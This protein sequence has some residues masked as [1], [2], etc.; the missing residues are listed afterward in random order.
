[1]LLL[2]LAFITLTG[3]YLAYLYGRKTKKFK[4]SEYT[5][6][7]VFPLIFILYMSYHQ[8]II[9]LFFVISAVSGFF[10]EYILGLTFHKT[11]NRRLWTYTRFHLHGYT[12]Y[13]S[14]P[15][16]GLAGVLFW[17]LSKLLGL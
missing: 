17:Q 3:F 5:A 9:I 12:S 10:L 7:V 2:L 15:V 13:L 11:L 6:V 4:W 16:W 14:I 1:M 8:P